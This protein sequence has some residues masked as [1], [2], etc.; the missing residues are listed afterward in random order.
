MLTAVS[1][2]YDIGSAIYSELNIVFSYVWDK[3]PP[4]KTDVLKA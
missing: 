4:P 1:A 3:G 2:M